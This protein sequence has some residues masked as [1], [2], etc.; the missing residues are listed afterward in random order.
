MRGP[1]HVIDGAGELLEVSPAGRR[2]DFPWEPTGAG[3]GGAAA[4]V[5]VTEADE[6]NFRGRPG[7]M[8][9]IGDVSAALA[10]PWE[11]AEGEACCRIRVPRHE[12]PGVPKKIRVIRKW[13]SAPL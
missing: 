5:G 11:V 8:D 1:I 4:P 10:V 3:N 13:G 12:C 2:H 9:G 7:S 6:V